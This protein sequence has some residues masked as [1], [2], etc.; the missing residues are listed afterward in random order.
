MMVSKFG[1]EPVESKFGGVPVQKTETG[2]VDE[3]G[4][5]A[6]LTGRAIAG[7]AA[8]IVE[9]FTEPVR[10]ILN[11][12]LPGSP[13][14]NIETATDVA[15]TA[16]GVPEPQGAVERGVQSVGRFATGFAGGF[17][18]AQKVDDAVTG[19]LGLSKHVKAGAATTAELKDI[20]SNA[21]K[22]ADDSG[23]VVRNKSFDDFVS[24]VETLTK[25][26]GIDRTIHPKATAAMG[27]LREAVESGEGIKLQD[28]E[29]LRRVVGA[30]RRSVDPDE[31][32]IGSIISDKMDEY[33]S[34]IGTGDVSSG[35]PRLAAASLKTARDA[36]ARMSKSRIVE[37]AVEKAGIRAG[38]F[39]GS[40]FENA[41]RT[42]FRQIAM[43]TKRMRGFTPEEQVA[44][45]KVASGGKLDNAFRT[46]GK[47]A[48]TGIVSAGIG[49]T[50]GF[51]IAGAPGAVAL[52]AVGAVARQVAT[53]RTERN[54]EALS[55]LVR[56]G[57]PAA[58]DAPDWLLPW[59]SG[60]AFGTDVQDN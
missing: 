25:K 47:L 30:A 46:L 40:G 52:P 32:R 29:I 51:A 9:P 22:L 39:S 2:F 4:R 38:Q 57:V 42:Q 49:G 27:R 59:L 14:G 20:A 6:G 41:L 5:Q 12:I 31:R 26:E 44:I 33:M 1:G 35:N 10:F 58:K 21:Y 24:G 56:S 3:L 60:G 23:L 11:K 45:K 48:P 13:I 8:Q 19:L 37:E 16:I 15:L 7:G 34:R 18:G 43:N 55:N 50:A 28:F 17:G 53:K 54:V 36:W